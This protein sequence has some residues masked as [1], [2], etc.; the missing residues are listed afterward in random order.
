MHDFLSHPIPKI[1]DHSAVG[2]HII[3]KY[4]ALNSLRIYGGK[5]GQS[6]ISTVILRSLHNDKLRSLAKDVQ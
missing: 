1:L 4:I 5:C 6:L 2:N 3:C